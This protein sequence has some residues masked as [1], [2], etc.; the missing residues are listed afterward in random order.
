MKAAL[1]ARF[2]TDKQTDVSIEDQ[3]RVSERCAQGHGFMVVERFSDA[4]I[5]GGTAQRPGYQQ[6]L[7]AGRQRKFDAI[8]TEDLKR[9]WREQAEQWR[10]I[11]E[12]YDLG[13]IITTVSGLDSRQP[14]FD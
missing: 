3:L 10:A 6:M 14:G 4:A 13:I 8:V 11:K 2:S 7:K 1:Y 12:L 9:L 5:S